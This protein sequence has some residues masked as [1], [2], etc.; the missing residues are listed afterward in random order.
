MLKVLWYGVWRRKRRGPQGPSQDDGVAVPGDLG[1]QYLQM[2]VRISIFSRVPITQER[3]EA[4]SKQK[5]LRAKKMHLNKVNDAL[6]RFL[7]LF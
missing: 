1:I 5:V 7:G 6:P 2:V 3:T 4:A